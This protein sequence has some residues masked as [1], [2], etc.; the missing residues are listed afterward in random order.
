VVADGTFQL[1][2]RYDPPLK[3]GLY[4]FLSDQV[5]TASGSDHTMSAA[6]TP[7]V[8]QLQTHVRVR[9]PQYALP[10]D[11]VLS[12]FPPANHE[13]SFGARLPQ[14]VIKRRTLPWERVVDEDPKHESLPWLALVLIAEGE[15]ELRLNQKVADCVTSG[16]RLDPPAD[17]EV[18]N[19]LAIRASAVK[20]LFPTQD[21][22]GLLAHVREVDISDTELMMGDDDGFLAVVISNRLPLPAKDAEGRPTPVTYLA[23]LVNLCG[24]LGALNETEPIELFTSDIPI[25]APPVALS[26]GDADKVKMRATPAEAYPHVSLPKGKAVSGFTEATSYHVTTGTQ[27]PYVGSS[28]WAG[29]AVQG[30]GQGQGVYEAM[31]APFG[32][33]VTGGFISDAVLTALD[34]ELRFPVLLH[35]SFTTTGND[36]FESLMQ[37]LSS[38]LLGTA[39]EDA[40][41][42]APGRPPFEVAETGHVGLGHRLRVGDQVRSWYRGPFVPHPTEDPPGGRLAIAHASDQLRIVVPD[43]REDLSLAAAFEIGRLL[44]LS[45]PSIVASLLRWRQAGFAAAWLSASYAGR[46]YRDLV[47]EL[48]ISPD[49]FIGGRLG[50]LVAEAIAAGP[51]AVLGNPSPVVSAGRRVTDA[52]GVELLA[53]GLGIDA[54][55]LTGTPG[56]VLG[57]LQ[58]T[59]VQLP[60]VVSQPGTRVVRDGLGAVLDDAFTRAAVQ[61]LAPQLREGTV[62]I[63]ADRLPIDVQLQLHTARVPD[64]AALRDRLGLRLRAGL[65]KKADQL[66]LL[67]HA[68]PARVDEDEEES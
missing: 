19:C 5:I 24:Q 27:A 18:G 6:D 59:E 43:G 11:Q 64:V 26:L 23:C 36:T 16:V 33:A 53:T 37:G 17:V 25:V 45:R 10:P 15:A 48:H 29:H 65:P 66:D 49:R 1:Y 2:P 8:E 31:A 47:D 63:D 50:A 4:R 21:E 38:G 34:P 56:S 12:T 54:K 46:G 40:Q 61:A 9:S 7:V 30:A 51:S 44:G 41:V 13:G 42:A 60:P 58:E 14:I 55:V 20:R 32:Y 67:M 35:W 3:A 52:A 28:A 57:R 68:V 22:V 39:P 62:T